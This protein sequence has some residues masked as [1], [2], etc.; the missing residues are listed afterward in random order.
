MPDRDAV[1]AVTP[2][3]ASGWILM[4]LAATVAG[5]VAALVYSDYRFTED[6]CPLARLHEY[7]VGGT[8][9]AAWAAGLTAGIGL[10]IRGFLKR[11]RAVVPGSLVAVIANVCMLLICINTVHDF[12]EADFSLKSTE[13]LMQILSEGTLDDQKMSAHELGER[14]APEAVLTLCEYLDDKAQDINLRHNAAIAL[15]K[16]CTPPRPPKATVDRALNS[17]IEALQ[18]REEFLPM[19]A[20]EA[21]ERIGDPRSIAPLSAL[22][23]DQTRNRYTRE[24]AARALARIGGREARSVLENAIASCDDSE[25]AGTIQRVSISIE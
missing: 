6:G 9:L 25:L 21:L 2:R 15:G 11:S 12:R 13:R 8:V 20:A 10:S 23:G 19:E 22:L 24:T 5:I 18:S 7:L 3:P 16:I 1:D 4:S 17:L 14:R